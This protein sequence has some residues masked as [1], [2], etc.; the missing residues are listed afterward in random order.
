MD[1]FVE[2]IDRRE[3]RDYIKKVVGNYQ[4]YVTLYGPPGAKVSCPIA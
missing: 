2:M 1:A 4:R 3:P